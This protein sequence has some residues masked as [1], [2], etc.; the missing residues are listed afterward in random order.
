MQ[1]DLRQG[2]TGTPPRPVA[3]VGGLAPYRQGR[4]SLQAVANP[5]KLSSN[6]SHRG[7]P[8]D[9][10]TAYR[11]AAATL[12][13]YPN[14]SQAALRSAIGDAFGL[15]PARIVCGNGSDEIISLLIRA[16]CVPATRW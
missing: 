5:L 14:G 16:T 8:P 3:G 6:E 7:A 15:D 2:K 9:A 13:R 1:D 10:V 4:I 12:N 11:A